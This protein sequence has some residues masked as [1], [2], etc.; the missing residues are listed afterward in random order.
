M[1][2]LSSR[3][4]PSELEAADSHPAP[5]VAGSVPDPL[6]RSA[7]LR[8]F[9]PR[10]TQRAG[11]R[12]PLMVAPALLF[13][14][15]FPCRSRH[16]FAV[17]V[18]VLSCGPMVSPARRPFS[19]AAGPRLRLSLRQRPAVGEGGAGAQVQPAFRAEVY[20]S[21]RSPGWLGHRCSRNPGC[22]P[23]PSAQQHR[24]GRRRFSAI[25]SVQGPVYRP[26]GLT[27]PRSRCVLGKSPETGPCR[28][29]LRRSKAGSLS[30][31][32]NPGGSLSAT[33]IL[34]PNGK[35]CLG[36]RPS[37]GSGRAPARGFAYPG[38]TSL[39]SSVSATN[40]ELYPQRRGVARC[41][42]GK[43]NVFRVRSFPGFPHSIPAV[44]GVG[45]RD[46]A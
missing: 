43:G 46:E 4:A 8:P 34:S 19:V 40:A 25:G 22:G 11:D 7:H 23:A 41:C 2:R 44:Q 26:T 14:I 24:L 39:G 42:P 6:E 45:Q 12:Q 13:D 15:R 3:G 20:R 35:V 1:A 36:R 17:R 37:A 5:P 32:R 9:R 33:G 10:W 27:R 28:D 16:R 21:A 29:R 38:R 31:G 18:G 30:I